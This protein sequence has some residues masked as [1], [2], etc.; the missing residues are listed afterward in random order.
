VRCEYFAD[1]KSGTAGAEKYK[2]KGNIHW[3]S[4]KSAFAAGVRSYDRLF[5]SEHSEGNADLNP[6]SKVTLMAQLEPSLEHPAQTM[7]QFERHGYY[8]VDS[9][10]PRVFNR[11]VTLRETWDKKNS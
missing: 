11:T 7:F 10:A 9:K 3:V 6:A 8:V 1:S 5:K 4:V 2:V